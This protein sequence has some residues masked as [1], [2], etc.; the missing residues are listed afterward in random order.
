MS[1][2]YTARA[3][4]IQSPMGL[5]AAVPGLRRFTPN[6]NRPLFIHGFGGL[7]D[8]VTAVVRQGPLLI[9]F[10]AKIVCARIRV[11][12]QLGTGPGIASIGNTSD[13]AA[14]LTKTVPIADAAGTFY[15]F[16]ED[17]EFVTPIIPADT[18]ISA[19]GDGGATSTGSVDMS[20]IYTPWS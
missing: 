1:K 16:D 20:I 4:D 10:R 17:A 6:W 5:I 7:L 3:E 9:P 14:Y 12:V 15:L 11:R 19:S 13:E 8:M 18:V 2:G